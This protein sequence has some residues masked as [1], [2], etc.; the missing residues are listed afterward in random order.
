MA[1]TSM[2]VSAKFLSPASI[3]T[4][5]PS[6]SLTSGLSTAGQGERRLIVM[7]QLL[8]PPLLFLRRLACLGI[9]LYSSPLSAGA[10]FLVFFNKLHLHSTLQR[11]F[12]A[13][14][15][16]LRVRVFGE[17]HQDLKNFTF[18]QLRSNKRHKWVETCIRTSLKVQHILDIISGI[19][20]SLTHSYLTNRKTMF[21]PWSLFPYWKL[22]CWQQ[23]ELL[24]T[25][26]NRTVPSTSTLLIR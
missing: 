20:S 1:V 14:S 19:F 17:N 22:S 7:H 15:N 2:I 6:L 8:W 24:C 23:Y 5:E 26:K 16:H 4:F 9:L 25:I 3:L 12:G 11:S 21:L 10:F 18:D 13:R